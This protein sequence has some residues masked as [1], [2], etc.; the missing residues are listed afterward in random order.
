M[1]SGLIRDAY[2][3]CTRQIVCEGIAN[4]LVKHLHFSE[5]QNKRTN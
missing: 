2:G 4:F 1:K 3:A 5:Y